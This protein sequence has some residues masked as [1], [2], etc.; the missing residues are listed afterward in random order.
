MSVSFSHVHMQSRYFLKLTVR[1]IRLQFSS[2]PLWAST[3][4]SS[5]VH[6]HLCLVCWFLLWKEFRSLC[7][8]FRFR[9][10]G[11][12]AKPTLF[13]ETKRSG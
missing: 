13:D 8:Y 3:Q 12:L 9:L 10:S 6:R 4:A 5:T 1:L 7:M 11:Y 2:V